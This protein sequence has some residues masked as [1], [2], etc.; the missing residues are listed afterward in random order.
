MKT[1][2]NIEGLD[3]AACAAELEEELGKIDGII[4]A[5][6]SFVM[7]KIALEYENEAALKKA[8]DT[9]NHF[10]E[11]RVLSD[12]SEKEEAAETD[13][14]KESGGKVVLKLEGLHCA[15][16]AAEL[17]AQIAKIRGIRQ[18]S[19]DFVGQKISLEAENKAAYEKAVKTANRFEKV[20]VLNGD[21][22]GKFVPQ[23]KGNAF[24]ENKKQVI[25]I[26]VS[27]VFFALGI[28]FAK[29][30]PGNAARILSYVCYAIAYLSVGYPVLVSTVKKETLLF[31]YC[32][33][34]SK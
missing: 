29:W 28:V 23:G 9:A 1:T 19:V 2:L 25:S 11:V 24:T 18:V 34:R 15:A 12:G 31:S 20:R 22:A 13:E 14:K 5:S 27:C 3:C 16:C 10:E 30:I 26:L 17:E 8:V 6:V 21:E 7:Q 33:D 32:R 4:S